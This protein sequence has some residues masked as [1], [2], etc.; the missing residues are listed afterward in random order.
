MPVRDP[1]TAMRL[2]IDPKVDFAF[3]WLFGSEANKPLLVHLLHAVLQ[4]P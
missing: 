1:D 2:G 3:K 4:L